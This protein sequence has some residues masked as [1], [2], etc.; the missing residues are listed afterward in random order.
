MTFRTY[1]EVPGGDVSGLGDQVA[2]L[3]ERVRVRLSPVRRAVA[4]M[5]GKGG[6]GKSFVTAALGLAAAERVRGRSRVGVLDADFEGPTA[7]KLLGASGPLRVT[8]QGVQPVP[9][10]SG[11]VVFSTDLLLEDGRPLAWRDP[12][13]HRFVWRGALEAG[14]LREFLADVAWGGLDLLLIDLP[15]GAHRLEDLADLVPDLAVL[16]V[17]IPSEES[18]RSVERT[19]HAAR[20]RRLPILGLVENMSGYACPGCGTTG[21]LFGGDAGATLAAQFGVPLLARVPFFPD[22]RPATA[23][24]ALGDAVS[25]V[26]P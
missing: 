5:S 15:P 22:A 16:A 25:A 14:A 17:T 19:L 7:A 8:D 21:P 4:V 2:A 26:L 3:R 10:R 23:V 6:V 24:D 13:G 12:S 18:R 20:E 1:H 9:G 11:V